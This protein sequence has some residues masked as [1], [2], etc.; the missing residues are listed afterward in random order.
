MTLDAA[1]CI[2]ILTGEQQR[3]IQ[4]YLQGRFGGDL[5]TRDEWQKFFH[6][7]KPRERGLRR[8]AEAQVVFALYDDPY[9]LRS[10]KPAMDW[11]NAI[12]LQ[13]FDSPEEWVRWWEASHPK[14]ALSEDGRILVV[15]K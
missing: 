2:D 3:R 12:T 13:T 4:E 5:S 8:L 9:E 1:S 7:P 11:L 15:G 14:F 6:A 10:Q